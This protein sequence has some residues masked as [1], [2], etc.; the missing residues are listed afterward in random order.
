MSGK[1][2]SAEE[3]KQS[4]QAM[5]VNL[6]DRFAVAVS[7]GVDSLALALL[8]DQICPI[9]TVTVDH[10]L[11]SDAA[12]EARY[13]GELMAKH[14]I[15]HTILTWQGEKPES[16]IQ[17]AAREARYKLIEAW[18]ITKEIPNL[19]LA[20]HMDDQAETFLLRL[21]RGSGVYGLASMAEKSP[22][23]G[24]DSPITIL[25]PL[26]KVTKEQLKATLTEMGQEW[27]EDPSNSDLQYDRVKAREYLAA[28]TL[29]N[30]DSAKLADTASRMQRAKEA[31]DY[32]AGALLEEAVT[33]HASGY[34]DVDIKALCAAPDE[35]GLRALARLVRH[36]SGAVYSPRLDKLERAYEA[37]SGN[38][39]K[40]QT[41]SGCQIIASGDGVIIVRE[42]ASVDA[43]AWSGAGLFDGRY[44]ILQSKAGDVKKLGEEGWIQVKETL[45][46][47][48]AITIPYQ[49]RLTLPAL[50]Q[51]D[52]VVSQPHLNFGTGLS[53]EFSPICAL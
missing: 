14:G 50:W 5:G 6:S 7:G 4:L 37:F 15:P 16:G 27:I 45:S 26:L 31:L 52:R 40:G 48:E 21:S 8:I 39:Y 32:Y 47:P 34:A 23:L 1:V 10:G 49:A 9:E 35:T 25:R 24:G 51:D 42:S 28:P 13:V 3:L 43:S 29:L 18:C 19:V 38:D 36:I 44:H 20:H 17:A 11:R 46:A 41:L 33:L 2:L 12:D 53:G 30:L 22:L